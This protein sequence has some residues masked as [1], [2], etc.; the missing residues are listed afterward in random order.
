MISGWTFAAEST[1][2][3]TVSNGRLERGIKLPN[4]GKNYSAYR[5]L[6]VALGRT[7]VHSKVSE[8][9][10]AAYLELEK[11]AASKKYVYGETG[12]AGGGR[13]KPHRTH[14]NGLSVDLWC[15]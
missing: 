5:G 8:I 12:W 3:G 9:V 4:A 10:L 14:R 6:G 2:Y 1:C 7:Y 15:R 11:S 13:I